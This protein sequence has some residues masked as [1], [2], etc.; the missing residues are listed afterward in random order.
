MT[1]KFFKKHKNTILFY[2]PS[3][4]LAFFVL[5]LIGFD[6]VK[7]ELSDFGF[8]NASIVVGIYF[9]R[10]TLLTFAWMRLL[11]CGDFYSV[12]TA[13]SV[14]VA[15]NA[16]TPGA[17]AGEAVKGIILHKNMKCGNIASS[18]FMLNIGYY[19]TTFFML[20]V[21]VFFFM[22]FVDVSLLFRLFL[23]FLGALF[24]FFSAFIFFGVAFLSELAKKLVRKIRFLSNHKSGEWLLDV[25]SALK[26][27][28]KGEKRKKFLEMTII[29][30]F[31]RFADI[32]VQ[33]AVWKVIFPSSG[34]LEAL[35]FYSM[36]LI[37]QWMT[38]LIPSGWGVMEG[39]AYGVGELGWF[40]QVESV[41]QQFISRLC[42]LIASFIYL[43]H[44]SVYK[45][46]R[47]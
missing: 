6:K 11:G 21:S 1:K 32:A 19:V 30:L 31:V 15:V 23:L 45:R 10:D 40:P 8:I 47:K 18:V 14:G 17:M 43:L 38:N 44:Y 33:Y 4:L 29:Q 27:D 35:F 39:A 42:K 24:L 5:Y 22:V 20:S 37:V 2:I 28:T 26:D 7:E 3:L 12:F 36:R 13:N 46:I 34:L 41:M 16:I 25:L 9:L